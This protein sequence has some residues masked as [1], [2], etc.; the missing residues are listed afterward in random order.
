MEAFPLYAH[1][2]RLWCLNFSLGAKGRTMVKLC[3][4]LLEYS[5]YSKG[6]YSIRRQGCREAI[7]RQWWPRVRHLAGVAK[8]QG[9]GI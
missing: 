8:E 1:L 3:G 5:E 9:L 2:T 4:P 6:V 7:C